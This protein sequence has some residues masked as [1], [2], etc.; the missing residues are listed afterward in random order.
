MIDGGPAD[1]PASFGTPAPITQLNAGANT[2]DP[3]LT[4]DELEIVFGSIR[5]GGAGSCDLYSSTRSTIT[6]AWSAPAALTTLVTNACDSNPMFFADG[7]GLRFVGEA[8]AANL[9]IFESMRA[10]RTSPWQARQSIV[11]TVNTVGEDEFAPTATNDDLLMIFTVFAGTNDLIAVS[12]ANPT[13]PWGTRTTV[14]ELAIGVERSAHLSPD[15]LALYYVSNAPGGGGGGEDLWVA[16]RLARTEPF[17]DPQPLVGVNSPDD[18]DDPWVSDDGNRIYF[19]RYPAGT[20]TGAR[21]YFS[22]R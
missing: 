22:S 6:A 8:G 3:A 15:G 2:D 21:L 16:T 7:L 10:S 12:R 14:G 5:P 20:S 13:D 9:D 17:G 19:A 18:E 11:G 1:G 4:H